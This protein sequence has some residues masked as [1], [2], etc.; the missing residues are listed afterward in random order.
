MPTTYC[1]AAQ[2]AQKDF[3]D[4]GL[5]TFLPDFAPLNFRSLLYMC[6]WVGWLVSCLSGR[7]LTPIIACS[8][9]LTKLKGIVWLVG[10]KRQ[11][12]NVFT[13]N[14]TRFWATTRIH[15]CVQRCSQL[16][17]GGK[18]RALR[19]FCQLFCCKNVRRATNFNTF[20]LQIIL[21]LCYNALA[22]ESIRRRQPWCEFA[23]ILLLE[24]K[25]CY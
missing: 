11:E 19:R 22:T 17:S 6:V 12:N 4:C 21:Q 15:N 1:A 8:T 2:G 13:F 7:F 5:Q 25:T 20:V 18:K 3:P 16:F 23:A 24:P 10:G 14:A 9:V